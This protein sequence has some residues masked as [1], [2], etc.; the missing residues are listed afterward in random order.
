MEKEAMRNAQPE[1][2]EDIG[3]RVKQLA[4][5]TA[6]AQDSADRASAQTEHMRLD[7]EE[8]K[9]FRRS[10]GRSVVGLWAFLVILALMV[11]GLA[12]YGFDATQGYAERFADLP[13]YEQTIHTLLQL[14]VPEV[15]DACI[16]DTV[17]ELGAVRREGALC[18]L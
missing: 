8:F 15:A 18:A 10:Q 17:D 6:R 13:N 7:M 11:G 2:P 12:W 14:A 4:L 9:E 1:Q 16:V 5:E 3:K